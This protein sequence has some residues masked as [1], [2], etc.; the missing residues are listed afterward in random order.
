MSKLANDGTPFLDCV[1][2]NEGRRLLAE[3]NFNV[4]KFGLGDDEVNYI[5]YDNT[6][7]TPDSNILRLPTDEACTDAQVALQHHLV[8]FNQQDLTYLPRA[9]VVTTTDGGNDEVAAGENAGFRV[10]LTDQASVD[11]FTNAG[12]ALPAGYQQ[13]VYGGSI[14]ASAPSEGGVV[15]DCGV[16]QGGIP[17]Y[18]RYN[19][20]AEFQE[21][22]F[23]VQLDDRF[24]QLLVPATAFQAGQG[25]SKITTANPASSVGIDDQNIRTYEIVT[26]L[27][28]DTTFFKNLDPLAASPVNGCFSA[29]RTYLKFDPTAVMKTN[30]QAWTS[31]R[32]P[33]QRITN[34]FSNVNA[35]MAGDADVLDT[36][37]K[38]IGGL[39]GVVA[40]GYLRMIKSV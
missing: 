37:W 20:P 21:Q 2:T 39:T 22:Y 17:G 8:S 38:I 25:S 18:D 16:I 9:A 32:F 26:S 12:V 7:N 15:I 3:G 31:G 11:K 5:L 4:T 13:A 1:L 19:K 33:T 35:A 30:T 28:S 24:L 40:T 23:I 14:A 10:L 6:S 27:A 34:W 36:T 29:P